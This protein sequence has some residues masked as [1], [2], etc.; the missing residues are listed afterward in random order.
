MRGGTVFISYAWGG[1]LEQKEWLRDRVINHLKL[2]DFDVFWDRDSI[3]FGQSIDQIIRNALEVRPLHVVCI[4]DQ[5]FIEG[6][7]RDNSGLARELRMIAD[8][9]GEDGVR[10]LP[11]I[12][13][14]QCRDTL[15]TVLADRMYLDLV[16]L[17]SRKLELGSVLRAAL[18]GASQSQITA[19]I[20]EQMEIASL[21]ARAAAY[22]ADHDIEICGNG[23]TH[24]V[25]T[26][27][28][29]LL[30]PPAWMYK[31]S[32]W[33]YRLA[34]DVEGFAPERGVWHWDHWTASTG[35]RGLGAAAMS[36]FFPA[37]IGDDD[38]SAIENC[39]DI[40]AVRIIAM[41]KKTEHLHF[42]WREMVQC[43]IT[44]DGGMR[45]LDHLLP[46]A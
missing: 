12:L 13:D 3:L 39:G 42:D 18:L 33:S 15:P 44:S 8:I 43:V 2:Y 32:R 7:K 10:I 6:S 45:A 40:L 46:A 5:E 21:R 16:S 37:M 1:S 35:M 9:A 29:N 20:Q 41:T 4:C 26:G 11:A 36:A 31:V 27:D 30:L 23:R 28:G 17:H 24:V 19:L 22:F 38:I 14:A 34:D 25:K